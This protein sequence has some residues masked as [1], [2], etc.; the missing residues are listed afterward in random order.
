MGVCKKG[1]HRDDNNFIA[2]GVADH[3]NT[4]GDNRKQNK[5]EK[6]SG[7]GIR[8]GNVA[9]SDG[10]TFVD[11][12]NNNH[13]EGNG[14]ND[15]I[16]DHIK[17]F[18][19]EMGISDGNANNA[20]P[21]LNAVADLGSNGVRNDNCIV[22]AGIASADSSTNN[23]G[24]GILS[25]IKEL[26]EELGI[27]DGNVN[28][29]NPA[30][31]VAAHPNSNVVDNTNDTVSART[32]FADSINNDDGDGKDNILNS[33]NGTVFD[34]IIKLEQRVKDLEEE[35]AEVDE[36][37]KY[38]RDCYSFIT[39]NGPDQTGWDLE[40][41][42]L[43]GFGLV[44]FMLQI[45]FSLLLIISVVDPNHGTMEENDNPDTN[46]LASFMPSNS[47]GLVK[48]T[49]FVSLST[50]V[51]FP[52][53]SVQDAVKV[54]QYW[55]K[56][57]RIEKGDP[58]RFMK[59]SCTLRCIQAT[60]S[61]CSVFF[62]VLTST[63][64]IEVILDFTAMN[65]VSG[66]DDVAF[67]LC[68]SGVFGPNFKKESEDVGKKDLPLCM[69]HKY[70]HF[71][72]W[73]TMG[74]IGAV[75]TFIFTASIIIQESKLLI[76]N[77]FRVQFEDETTLKSYSGCYNVTGKKFLN[78]HV[79]EYDS[80]NP[81]VTA[82][83]SFAY[84]K[85]D[86]QWVFSKNNNEDPCHKNEEQVLARSIKTEDFDIGTSFEE[87]WL[88]T[89]DPYKPVYFFT[90]ENG[91][92][93]HCDK[94]L[95]DGRCDT[96][97]NK[98]IYQ[99]DNGDCCA[100]T[101]THRDCS[102]TGTIK[103]FGKDVEGIGFPNCTGEVQDMVNITIILNDIS[104]SRDPEFVDDSSCAFSES[105]QDVEL[106]KATKKASF[107]LECN[108][109]TVLSLDIE[110]SMEDKTDVWIEDG[111]DCTLKIQNT[112]NWTDGRSDCASPI[113]F[114]HYTVF[115]T[116]KS[117]NDP[118]EILSQHTSESEIANFRVIPDCYFEKLEDHVDTALMYNGSKAVDWLLNDTTGNSECDDVF[119]IERF[120]LS[121]MNFEMNEET[122]L[123][124]YTKQC[125][126]PSWP[127]IECSA[128]QVTRVE[129][130]RKNLKGAIPNEFFLLTSLDTLYMSKLIVR[131][132]T[133]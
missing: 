117:E 78:R 57:K 97:L 82:S 115:K 23:D 30:G 42:K 92:K 38:P 45:T 48:I 47:K 29:T 26:E 3:S 106:R 40:K 73:K 86:H 77:S 133:E 131:I 65:F 21:V 85:S 19:E 14:S 43:F 8:H 33:S 75:F 20:A 35:T 56:K 11:S 103:A 24:D 9:D 7:N 50:Y 113:W 46:F 62:L 122:P 17:R 55:P 5:V 79:Y 119:F 127:W 109:V 32:P 90:F 36:D 111:V 59:L 104:S 16:F 107:N 39:L 100:A 126:I 118:V 95:G 4:G 58:V 114:I 6:S 18:E 64:V 83:A 112:T 49:Q 10:T 124:N 89:S 120:A 25:Q 81:H 51:L 102:K 101:C 27:D 121:V 99:Y 130:Q 28:N 123:L 22:S 80:S 125:A 93:F 94:I 63:S 98:K 13:G 87:S 52:D 132:K 108:G 69:Q 61:I 15:S 96:E 34:H 54:I 116:I 37:K 70:K 74:L 1:G 41:S 128:G 105:E 31:S 12:S 110:D 88:I 76:T 84:C 67:T 129:L 68:E 60:L 44:V 71:I 91:E 66:F 53:S 2:K 72:H